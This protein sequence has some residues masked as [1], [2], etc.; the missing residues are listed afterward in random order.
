MKKIHVLTIL[1]FV[2]FA[3]GSPFQIKAQDNPCEPKLICVNTGD[4]LKYELISGIELYYEFGKSIDKRIQ[5]TE[6][7]TNEEGASYVYDFILDKETSNAFRLDD[8]SQ[9]RSFVEI[10]ATPIALESSITREQNFNV[11]CADILFEFKEFKRKAI[12]CTSETSNGH[13][14]LIYDKETGIRLLTEGEIKADSDET[15]TAKWSTKL[16]DTN[17]ISSESNQDES[18]SEIPGWVKNI[19]IWYGQNK[20]SEE[21]LL[22]A[23]KFLVQH[24]IIKID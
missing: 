15:S 11:S 24:K 4:Y 9:T 21:D 16:I 13:I 19:F 22:G 3:I 20:V 6:K 12:S 14:E 5:F 10:R 2:L 7:G 1:I 23:I 8:P 17:M 18:I